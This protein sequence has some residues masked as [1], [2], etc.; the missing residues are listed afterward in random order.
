MYSR[1]GG[2]VLSNG[3][4]GRGGKVGLGDEPGRNNTIPVSYRVWYM[5]FLT[6]G[7]QWSRLHRLFK[8][9][10]QMDSLY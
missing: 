8:T 1:V 9:T 7:F 2:L 6:N 5:G 4:T 10:H 3:S